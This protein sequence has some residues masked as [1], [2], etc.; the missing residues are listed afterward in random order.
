M[1]TNLRHSPV[2]YS[3]SYLLNGSYCLFIHV[4]CVCLSPS[5][6]SNFVGK[7]HNVCPYFQ[8]VRPKFK[9]GWNS[10]CYEVNFSDLETYT[11]KGR[12]LKKVLK[13]KIQPSK[14]EDLI[15]FIQPIHGSGSIPHLVNRKALHKWYKMGSFYRNDVGQGS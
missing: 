1:A 6:C 7:R 10:D 11:E 9:K 5:S 15:G 8:M 13:Y 2:S 3:I 14:L 4:C 12:H